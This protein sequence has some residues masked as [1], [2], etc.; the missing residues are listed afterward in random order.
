MK[1]FD[2]VVGNPNAQW[3]SEVCQWVANRSGIP[4][5]S[6]A[7]QTGLER[8]KSP[9]GPSHKHAF[10]FTPIRGSRLDQVELFS[11]VLSRRFL[12]RGDFANAASFAE[13]IR[14]WSMARD[15]DHAR[16]HRWTYTGEPLVRATPFG[17]TRRQQQRGRAGFGTRPPLWERKLY[18]PRP[19]QREV[20]PL[21]ANF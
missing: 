17:Q 12:E 4:S 6:R 10:P 3:S 16:P 13:R 9:T 1:R 7:F 8:R 14:R 5:A 18:P 15:G 19:Y 2:R 20:A 11:R 21:A